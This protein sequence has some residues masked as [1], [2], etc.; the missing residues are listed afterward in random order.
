[1]KKI[2]EENPYD[3]QEL[4]VLEK[5]VVEM[6]RTSK[7]NLDVAV[8]VL[9]LYQFSQ[10]GN[11]TQ[12]LK[13]IALILVKCLMAL[14]KIDFQLCLR[15]IPE[16]LHVVEPVKTL[17][18]VYDA[19]EGGRFDEY[20]TLHEQ[21]KLLLDSVKDYTT[22]IRQY[23]GQ[24]MQSSQRRLPVAEAAQSLHTSEEEAVKFLGE[25]GWKIDGGICVSPAVAQDAKGR[26]GGDLVD[27]SIAALVGRAAVSFDVTH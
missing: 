22:T 13:H 14:P 19:L 12:Q 18:S 15:L 27:R 24:L 4:P 9:K 21:A 7:Y 25:Q 8:A 20:W 11:Q 10:D 1:V 16:K 6:S 17:S 23:I 5:Y 3:E 26:G 2:L